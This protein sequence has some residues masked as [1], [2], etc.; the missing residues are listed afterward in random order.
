MPPTLA[1]LLW[2]VLLLALLCFD[3]ARDSNTSLALW[4]PLIWMFIVGSRLP[5]QWSGGAFGMAAEAL[6]EGDAVDRSFFLVLILLSL[7]VLIS[8]SFRWVDFFA[9][10]ITL[11]AFLS[12]AL[13]S[14]IW[15]DF[16]FVSFKRW[17]RD[18]GSYL[19]ILVVLSDNRPVDAVRTLLRRFCYL[20]VPLSILLAKYYPGLAIRYSVWTGGPEYVGATTSKNMLGVACLI[21]GI[22]L[23]WDTVTRWSDRRE[24]RTKRILLLNMAFMAMTLWLLHLSNSATSR[25]C[26]MIGC[27]TIAVARS[28]VGKRHLG[29]VKLLIPMC[30]CLY[31]V[32]AL[33]FGL[34]SNLAEAVGRDPTL[35]DRTMIWKML[36]SLGTNPLV[37]TGYE[38]F[39][40]GP[41]LQSIWQK[42]GQINEAHNGYLGIYLELGFIGLFLLS[43]FLIASYRKICKSFT[44]FSPFASLQLALWGILIFY[45]VTEAAF[46]FHLMWFTFLL[47]AIALPTR[48]E[49]RLRDISTF[50]TC[51]SV[52]CSGI[53]FGNRKLEKVKPSISVRKHAEHS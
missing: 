45:N 38:S 8:R 36:L 2:I 28:G 17:F 41:R 15:S 47:G 49:D 4:V 26:L 39:W 40:L 11:L 51:E 10:N 9:H 5:S 53:S 31:L 42:F 44:T 48:A 13:L 24:W 35:T 20:L 52:Q 7:M 27:V 3:P 19:M 12:F 34:N 50:N 6:E 30:F 18:L 25:V 22:F 14:I 37:G 16:P 1:L 21:S 46:R 23:F 43:A 29:F 33:G 32:L